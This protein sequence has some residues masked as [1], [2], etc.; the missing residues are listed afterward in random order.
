MPAQALEHAVALFPG[1]CPARL[2]PKLDDAGREL[3]ANVV[4][5]HPRLR[6]AV[7][8]EQAPERWRQLRNAER[9]R[10][11][12]GRVHDDEGRR[13]IMTEARPT[14]GG[15]GERFE[16]V[17]RAGGL[18]CG[19]VVVPGRDRHRA[20]ADRA[21]ACDVVG[22]IADDDEIRTR[23]RRAGQLGGAAR[24]DRRQLRA[25]PRI[26]AVRTDREPP[27]LEAR[28]AQLELGAVADV[29]RQQP[30][31]RPARGLVSL[32]CQQ[33]RRDPGH[34][35]RAGPV[36][37]PGQLLPQCCDVVPAHRGDQLGRRR[38]GMAGMHEQFAARSAGRS[39]RRTD[40]CRSGRPCP[41]PR[42]GHGAPRAAPRRRSRAACRRYRRGQDA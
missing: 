37:R 20:R 12:E 42:A 3:L 6:Q 10:D 28:R 31:H 38:V 27:R 14:G 41:L 17:G 25:A 7:R 16:H 29:A 21:P 39:C 24:R 4:E 19:G 36:R 22:C 9:H 8:Y 5:R 13:S 34:Q 23:E 15:V 35:T 2:A 18:E 32:E 40:R 1:R 33:Q 11:L 26:G 30:D